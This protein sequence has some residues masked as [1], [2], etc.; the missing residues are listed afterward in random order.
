MKK[1]KRELMGGRR[2]KHVGRA[3]SSSKS[4]FK[5]RFVQFLEKEAEEE[6]EEEENPTKNENRN[7]PT[8]MSRGENYRKS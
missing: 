8:E 2:H 6:E 7:C 5:G 4:N 3:W 1:E